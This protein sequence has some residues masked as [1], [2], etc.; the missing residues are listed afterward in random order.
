M[1]DNE[2]LRKG[3]CDLGRYDDG[4]EGVTDA[5]KRHGKYVVTYEKGMETGLERIRDNQHLL[6]LP[7]YLDLAREAGY[8]IDVNKGRLQ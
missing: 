4:K 3:W 1:S 6:S 2:A 5:L 8:S 7:E